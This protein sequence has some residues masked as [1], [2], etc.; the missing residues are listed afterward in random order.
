MVYLQ[1]TT[2]EKCQIQIQINVGQITLQRIFLF[3]IVQEENCN[4]RETN[5]QSQGVTFKG[6]GMRRPVRIEL[7]IQQQ[8]ISETNL[9]TIPL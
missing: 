6:Q 8:L 7:T 2:H 5:P 1:Y 4:K 3:S 9:L